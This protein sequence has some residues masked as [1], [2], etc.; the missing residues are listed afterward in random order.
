MVIDLNADVGESHGACAVGADA[1]LMPSITSANIAAGFHGGDPSVLRKTV[2]LAKTCGVAVGAHPGYPDLKGFGRRE[3]RLPP[4]EVE[5][6][7]LYQI[8]AVAG[9]A[10]TEG[11]A[12]Q[13]VKPHGALYNTAARDE[14]LADA[15]VR[16][17]VA[18]DRSLVLFAPP[19]SALLKAGTAHGIRVAAEGF[20]DRAYQPDGSLASRQHP[21]AVI[22][23]ARTVIARALRMVKERT[24]V[25]VDGA[26]IPLA[27]DTL[28]IHSDTP[29][30][31]EL[32]AA[33][34]AGLEAAGITIAAA[35]RR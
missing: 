6:L 33:L 4:G 26:S 10:R 35:L 14:A 28:C 18:F 30:A 21:G 3:M 27:I 29:G 23:D 22:T 16:A 25:A 31:G 19:A 2:R 24:V 15:I 7:V 9:V 13:H 34:R 17:I 5:D 12:L 1:S 11:V 20:A 32:A 8:A